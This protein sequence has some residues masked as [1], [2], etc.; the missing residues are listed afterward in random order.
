MSLED[1]FNIFDELFTPSC[2]PPRINASEPIHLCATSLSGDICTGDAGG[3][4][5][6]LDKDNK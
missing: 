3:A 5:A 4:L 1:C 2:Y 6:A